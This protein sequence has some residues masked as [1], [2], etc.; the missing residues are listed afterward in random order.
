MKAYR[1]WWRPVYN[2]RFCIIEIDEKIVLKSSFDN[3]S[4]V[5]ALIE[6]EDKEA[7]YSSTVNISLLD[8]LNFVYSKNINSY[9]NNKNSLPL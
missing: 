1:S 9:E 2:F 4:Y 7:I 3:G 6:W 8:L 5:T